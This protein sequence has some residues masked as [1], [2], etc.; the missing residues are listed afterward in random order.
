MLNGKL[1]AIFKIKGD[2]KESEFVEKL[3]VRT[4]LDMIRGFAKH[5]FAMKVNVYLVES[6]AI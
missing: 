3:E 5:V 1:C 2:L 6:C 4:H